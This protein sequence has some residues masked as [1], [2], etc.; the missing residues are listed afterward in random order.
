[1]E[2]QAFALKYRPQN[3]DEVVGQ[4]QVVE[5][6]K[7]AIASGRVHH[8]YLFSGPRGVGKTSLARIFARALN[9]AEGPTVNPCGRCLSCREITSGRSLDVIEID[10]A[11]NRGI[12]DIRELRENVKLSPAHA[13]YKIYI[14]DEVHQITPDGFNALLKTLEEP[15]SHVKFIFATTHPQKVLPTILSRCQKFQFTLLP[16][17]KIQKKLERIVTL[18][19]LNVKKDLLYSIARAAGGSIRDAESLLDQVAP[20]IIEKGEVDEIIS[21]LGIISEEVLNSMVDLIVR[22]DLTGSLDF[23]H[24][25]ESEGKDLTLF[26]TGLIEHMRHVLI[27][28]VSPQT[29]KSA[30]YISPYTKD[31]LAETSSRI[32]AARVLEFIDLLIEAKDLARKLNSVMIPF[33]LAIIKFFTRQSLQPSSPLKANPEG[34]LNTRP[35][36]KGSS[37]LKKDKSVDT[38]KEDCDFDIDSLDINIDDVQDDGELNDEHVQ[39]RRG[40]AAGASL[41]EILHHWPQIITG[42]KKERVSVASYL[43]EGVLKDCRGGVLRIA[44][45]R[46]FSFHKEILES[47]RNTTY[48]ES[49]IA[50]HL[51]KDIRVKFTF[52]SPD[53]EKSAAVKSFTNDRGKGTDRDVGEDTL[54][55]KQVAGETEFINEL[56]DTFKGKIHTGDE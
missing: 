43:N 15:P 5:A 24:R 22:G 32:P 54:S 56:L 46:K 50:R 41:D 39:E 25:I 12:D 44:F 34:S 4:E 53:E 17:E 30:A 47:A 23:I 55:E 3:F 2:Y 7:N 13:R 48:I 35:Q 37:S 42:I 19:G 14:I 6:L 52:L 8:A 45:S 38:G 16:V 11:S 40:G 36:K 49:F 51:G 1:M 31:F 29:L 28:R 27:A 21:F 18:E 20:I 33:E 9:C 10:G 26:L